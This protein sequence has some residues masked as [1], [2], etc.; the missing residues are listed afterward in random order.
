MASDIP[1]VNIFFDSQVLVVIQMFEKMVGRLKTE[2]NELRQTFRIALG[3]KIRERRTS[4]K[5]SLRAFAED[6][7]MSKSELS[8]I[9]R[10]EHDISA[11][12]LPIIAE[13]LD[14]SVSRL[15]PQTSAD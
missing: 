5:K 2:V 7:G 14:V 15:I 8:S 4:A 13:A 10:G 1:D 9:E 12:W 6:T 11:S 3:E